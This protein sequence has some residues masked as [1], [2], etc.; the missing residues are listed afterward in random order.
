MTLA[1]GFHRKGAC[2]MHINVAGKH[3]DLSEALKH[4]V[5]SQL[6]SIT[7]RYFEDAL[8]ADV[9]F[10]RARSFFTC[11]INV[12][13]GRGLTLRGE[14]EAFDAHSAFDD[15]A[16]H[17]SRRLRRYRKRVHSQGRL[18]TRTTPY[19]ETA[20]SYVLQPSEPEESPDNE[21]S[22]SAPTY[23]TIIAEQKT[24]IA[25]LPVSEAVMRLDLSDGPLLVF[26]N[27]VSRQINVVYRRDDG[28]IGWID[29]VVT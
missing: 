15:A 24:D 16:E 21:L 12:H 10:G 18:T 1:T 8:E 3:L 7:T 17:I 6:S 4:R 11:D 14:G 2:Q 25:F 19:A 27:S 26:R 28:N 29:P 20:N 9:T 5:S 22:T 23:A 13:A